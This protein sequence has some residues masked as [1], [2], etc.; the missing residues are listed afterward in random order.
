[1]QAGFGRPPVPRGEEW[2]SDV[3]RARPTIDPLGAGRDNRAGEDDRSFV[4]LGELQ[5]RTVILLRSMA[6]LKRRTQKYCT[7]EWMRTV[8]GDLDAGGG[9]TRR[10][11]TAPVCAGA[12][13]RCAGRRRP[14]LGEG[15]PQDQP[16][17]GACFLAR[18]PLTPRSA[19]L[20]TPLRRS[21]IMH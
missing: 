6:E 3:R 12:E 17:T 18:K 11:P 4:P 10:R 14:Q 19:L 7:P 21:S 20:S 2:E 16:V 13:L 9:E 1:D 5:G 15:R 8:S